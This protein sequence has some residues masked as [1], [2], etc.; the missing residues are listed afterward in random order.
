ME[1]FSEL[2]KSRIIDLE[3]ACNTRDLGGFRTASGGTVKRGLIFRSDE[4]SSLT[5]IGVMKLGELGVKTIIDFRSRSEVERVGENPLKGIG[6]LELSL[7][8]GNLESVMDTV[9]ETTGPKIMKLVNRSLVRENT[10]VFRE[11]FSLLASRENLPLLFHCAA[12]KDRT[13]FAAAMFL[14]SLG[15]SRGDIMN[16]YMLST[17]GAG[18]VVLKEVPPN[19]TVVGMRAKIVKINGKKVCEGCGR[20]VSGNFFAAMLRL[21]EEVYTLK[22]EIRRLKGEPEPKPRRAAVDIEIEERP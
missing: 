2:D 19:S 5:G 3:G 15:V 1:Q 9:N 21:E 11:F 10:E 17:Y 6:T 18:S 7:D 22:K 14:S 8:C 4:L 16:D 12:G 13:G 20:S